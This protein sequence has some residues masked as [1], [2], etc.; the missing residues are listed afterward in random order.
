[1]IFG[2]SYMKDYKDD[3]LNNLDDYDCIVR[4]EIPKQDEEPELYA[5]VTKHM[6]HGPCGHIKPNAP[7]MKNERCKKGYPKQFAECTMQ[8]NDSYP[9]YQRRNDNRS[10]ALDNN[11]EVVVENSWVVPYNPWLLLKYDCHINVEVCSNI[12]SVRYLYKYVYKG[13]DCVVFEVRQTPN[14]DEINQYVDGRWIYAP[15]ALNSNFQ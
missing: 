15:E 14:Y 9:I 5:A 13:P 1:M 8:G 10:I 2:M 6:I 4:A 11:G 7:C 3:K 12:K